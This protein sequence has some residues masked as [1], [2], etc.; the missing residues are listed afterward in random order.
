M[1][2]Q[3]VPEN[4]NSTSFKHDLIKSENGL[5]KLEIHSVNINNENAGIMNHFMFK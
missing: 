3:S 1:E 5:E 2:L 4:T